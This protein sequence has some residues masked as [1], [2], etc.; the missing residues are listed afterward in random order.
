MQYLF[1]GAQ[2]SIDVPAP[3]TVDRLPRIA[4]QKGT[5][6][7]AVKQCFKNP[8]LGGIG[9]L[10]FVDDPGFELF[11]ELES[12]AIGIFQ[13]LINNAY[14]IGKGHKIA[15]GCDP[16]ELVQGKCQRF[17]F[18]C[19]NRLAPERKKL[20]TSVEKRFICDRFSDGTPVSCPR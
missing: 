9:I 13:C 15:I 18:Q 8:V 1:F 12:E 3:E 14:L 4:D 5:A 11:P 20:F 7:I 2:I 19:G 10:K 17:G 16:V 6:V